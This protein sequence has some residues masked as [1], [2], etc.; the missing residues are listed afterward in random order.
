MAYIVDQDELTIM[1]KFWIDGTDIYSW[2][3]KA[4][5][6]EGD[7]IGDV[8]QTIFN[9]GGNQYSGDIEMDIDGSVPSSVGKR[10]FYCS[11]YG[12]TRG[13]EEQTVYSIG[14]TGP[15]NYYTVLDTPENPMSE[16]WT[17]ILEY[18]CDW[19]SGATTDTSGA[20]LIT[21]GIYNDLGDTDYDI[22]YREFSNY[23]QYYFTFKLSDFLDSLDAISGVR[24]NCN[25]T[26]N[27]FNV[28]TNA[29]GISAEGRV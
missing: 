3:A 7:D 17:P 27:L 13:E 22:D 11:W 24:V 10:Y 5:A 28:F 18:A 15:H 2:G 19:A 25:D 23:N 16:P 20:R 9:F 26:G 8:E 4:I 1:A 21:E 14:S 12:V 6:S 29:I